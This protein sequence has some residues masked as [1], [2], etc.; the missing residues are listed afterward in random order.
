MKVSELIEKLKN[1]PQNYD[2][3]ICVPNGD[4]VICHD[5]EKYI[6]VKAFEED[7][8]VEIYGL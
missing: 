3:R 2:I 1:V 4:E 7:K 8:I 5:F 6:E